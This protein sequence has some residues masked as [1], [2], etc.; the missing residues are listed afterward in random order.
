MRHR[1]RNIIRRLAFCA[2]FC[3][4]T[5]A[6]QAATILKLSLGGV[7]PDVGMNS[8]GILSTVNDSEATTLGD[9]NTAVDFTSFL[10]FIPDITTNTASFSLRNLVEVG[11]AQVLNAG[12]LVIQNYV[13]GTF[14]LYDP[15]NSLLL[16]GSVTNSVLSGVIGSPGTG[17]LFTTT[18]NNF[19][20]GSLTQY[21]AQGTLSLSMNMTNVNGGAGFAVAG[22]GP[23][24]NP[25][26]ADASVDIA[27]GPVPEPTTFAL[28]ALGAAA[29]AIARWRR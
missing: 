15:A 24:L 6:T 10:S 16:S 7:G 4:A 19:T 3:V 1:A 2:L 5:S 25:F 20:G 11:P 18:L 23:S 21:L 26:L 28:V 14:E 13:G 17:A 27:A 8:A 29:F 9:Q 12:T 22:G